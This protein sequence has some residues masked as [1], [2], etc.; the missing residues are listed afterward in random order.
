MSIKLFLNTGFSQHFI[1]H[2]HY[3]VC[4][5]ESL[6]SEVDYYFPNIQTVKQI[7]E[8]FNAFPRKQSVYFDASDYASIEEVAVETSENLSD[9]EGQ[10]QVRPFRLRSGT[11]ISDSLSTARLKFKSLKSKKLEFSERREGEQ[12]KRE[13]I[14]SQIPPD[15]VSSNFLF[16]NSAFLY[17]VFID[18]IRF[19]MINFSSVLKRKY[20]ATEIWI[21][22]IIKITVYYLTSKRSLNLGILKYISS[23]TLTENVLNF[24]IKITIILSSPWNAFMRFYLQPFICLNFGYSIDSNHVSGLMSRKIL[25]IMFSP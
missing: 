1:V 17:L 24:S 16:T 12:V 14:I 20:L 3:V 5:Y 21:F 11:D 10:D 9:T 8:K 23:I 2:S 7:Q 25:L 4:R 15:F 13:L 22:V 6:S 18:M 19:E